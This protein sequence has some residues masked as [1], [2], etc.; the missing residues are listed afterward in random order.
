MQLEIIYNQKQRNKVNKCI[1]DWDYGTNCMELNN[2]C[3]LPFGKQV[4]FV[5]DVPAFTNCDNEVVSKH[6]NYI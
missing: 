6:S 1:N 2:K 3:V 4:G 5:K